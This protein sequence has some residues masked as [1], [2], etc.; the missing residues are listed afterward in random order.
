MLC[1]AMRYFYQIRLPIIMPL[2]LAAMFYGAVLRN[3]LIEKQTELR[4]PLILITIF[5]FLSL[6]ITQKM[7]YLD[8]WL[9]W[10]MTQLGAFGLFYLLVTKV[11]LTSSFAVYMGRISYS[12]YLLHALVI[13]VVF[14]LFDD[15][16][17]T[18]IGFYFVVM[19]TFIVSILF[20][21]FSYRVIEK[22]GVKLARKFTFKELANS[23]NLQK[24]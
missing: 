18:D 19:V 23:E 1:A 2:G 15:F 3:Y 6:M 14:Y 16:A 12:L 21:D 7:Y 17:F 10:F 13:G 8:G 20:A 4:V 9:S 24:C 22:P 5:Y 11:K